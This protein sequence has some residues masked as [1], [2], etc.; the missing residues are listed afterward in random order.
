MAV[1]PKAQSGPRPPPTTNI[2]PLAD[3]A[4]GIPTVIVLNRFPARDVARAGLIV[5][6]LG[7]GLY[8]LWLLR[9][10]IFLMFL[11]VMVAT[12]IE[13]LVN[14]LRRGPFTRGSGTLTV[15]ALIV[16]AIAL[17]TYFASPT[18]TDQMTGFVEL[19]PERL[20]SLRS[21]A[22]QIQVRPIRDGILSALG[23]AAAITQNPAPTEPE[24]AIEGAATAAHTLFNFVTV[25]V[26]A[27][28]WMLERSAIKRIVLKSVGPKWA[29]ETNAAWLEVEEKL[30]GWVRGQLLL[31]LAIAVMA[32][33]GY[34][35][36]GLPNP[37]LLA[38]IAGLAEI[39]PILGPFIAFAPA[40]LIGLTISPTTA[41]VVAI[42][43][44]VIQQFETYVLVPRIMGHTVG[45][46]PLTVFLGILIGASLYGI[47]GAF[48][49]VPIAGLAQVILAHLLRSE[50]D[51][52]AEAHLAGEAEGA[53]IAGQPSPSSDPLPP[54]HVAA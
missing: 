11:A 39:I 43:A 40:I 25:F 10:I 50:D 23:A 1:D 26:L 8:F 9:E 30:G 21:H 32:G 51:S 17:P 35:V 20:G 52:Q 44:I 37:L 29:P 54:R 18:L 2:D 3:P 6:A 4:S 13:P 34:I 22:E 41:L 16:L 33:L 36:V 19:L 24:K 42:Y 46:S 12:A 38:V 45:V 31:M 48:L 14:R 5:L 27:F 7:L 15:Y 53:A 47:P 28:Y 49:A